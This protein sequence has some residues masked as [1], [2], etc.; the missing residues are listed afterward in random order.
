[1]VIT[2]SSSFSLYKIVV[3][4][5]A[6]SPNIFIFL[7]SFPNQRESTLLYQSPIFSKIVD[8]FRPH[9]KLFCAACS[10]GPFARKRG[11]D[12]D[13]FAFKG[14]CDAARKLEQT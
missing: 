5:A 4:P 11:S 8:S 13:L 3:F 10:A 14:K 1:M 12:H 7:S 6:S 9:G 2:T